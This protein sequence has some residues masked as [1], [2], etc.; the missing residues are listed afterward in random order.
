MRATLRREFWERF[1][2]M[3]SAS[4]SAICLSEMRI[5]SMPISRSILVLKPTS[6]AIVN[7]ETV[8]L[9]LAA[10]DVVAWGE[11]WIDWHAVA[12][13]GDS[14]QGGAPPLTVTVTR[15]KVPHLVKSSDAIILPCLRGFC[16]PLNYER[17][18]AENFNPPLRTGGGSSAL[19]GVEFSTDQRRLSTRLK[20]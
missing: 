10:R 16:D 19:R 2:W 13:V 7:L 1:S 5:G 15:E 12:V 14:D 18:V 8:L 3:S 9:T 17:R 6:D 11:S 4:L 20:R